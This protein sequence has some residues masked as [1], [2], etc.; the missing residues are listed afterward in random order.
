MGASRTASTEERL[1]G[2][3]AAAHVDNQELILQWF[4]V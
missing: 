1:N 4:Y 3:N 2:C